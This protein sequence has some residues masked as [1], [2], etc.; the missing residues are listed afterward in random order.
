MHFPGELPPERVKMA[1]E[2]LLDQI[3]KVKFEEE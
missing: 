2:L 1:Y 3:L